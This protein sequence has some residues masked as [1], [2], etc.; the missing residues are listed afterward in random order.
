MTTGGLDDYLGPQAQD[1]SNLP[2]HIED[3]TQTDGEK[4]TQEVD[5]SNPD[6]SG[7]AVCQIAEAEKKANQPPR[8]I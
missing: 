2:E 8:A 4:P 1:Y 3:A 7:E 6:N 5:C